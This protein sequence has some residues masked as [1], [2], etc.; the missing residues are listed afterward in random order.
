VPA[1][2]VWAGS[3]ARDMGAF[4]QPAAAPHTSAA[5]AGEALFFIFGILLMVTLF[6]MPVFPSFV[7]IDW[8]DEAGWLPWIQGDDMRIR[9]LRYFL[10]AFPASAVLIILTALVSAG[11]RWSA[12]PRL[13]PGQFRCTAIPT[14][15]NGW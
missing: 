10:L 15:P 4:E 7:L 14:A 2:R 12:L 5:R 1:G 13:K 9:L 6:F 11:I 8:F 3:P